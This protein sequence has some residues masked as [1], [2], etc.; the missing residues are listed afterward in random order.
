MFKWSDP[1]A[2]TSAAATSFAYLPF[3]NGLSAGNYFFEVT[4]IVNNTMADYTSW[5]AWI[6][7]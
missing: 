5:G 7:F 6:G 2:K 1:G 4:I 3:P